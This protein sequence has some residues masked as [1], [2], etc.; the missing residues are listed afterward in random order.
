MNTQKAR[1]R[2]GWGGEEAGTGSQA[3]VETGS[4]F[5]WFC[6]EALRLLGCTN[7]PSLI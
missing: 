6:I 1:E 2:W 3:E 4:G 7:I 5:Y